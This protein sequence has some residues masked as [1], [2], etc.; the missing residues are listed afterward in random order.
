MLQNGPE[1]VDR[2]IACRMLHRLGKCLAPSDR[3]AIVNQILSSNL[4][5]DLPVLPHEDQKIVISLLAGCSESSQA[6]KAAVR[7]VPVPLLVAIAS[8]ASNDPRTVTMVGIRHTFC[9]VLF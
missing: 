4:V 8:D 1:T 5:S 6:A 2:V 7:K 3:T 9:A